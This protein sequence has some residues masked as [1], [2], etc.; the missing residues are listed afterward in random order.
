MVCRRCCHQP[1]LLHEGEHARRSDTLVS[2]RQGTKLRMG[3]HARAVE[4]ARTLIGGSIALWE[5]RLAEAPV[6]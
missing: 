3:Q 4:H 1:H 5:A 6:E 2:H